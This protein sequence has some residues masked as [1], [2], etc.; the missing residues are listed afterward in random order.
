[1]AT[2][3]LPPDFSEFL[4]LLGE[5]KSRPD[6]ESNIRAMAAYLKDISLIAQMP[7]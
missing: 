6:Q 2:I 7:L 4:R 3:P 5:L 1:M